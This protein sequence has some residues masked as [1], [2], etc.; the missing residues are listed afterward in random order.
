MGYN[1]ITNVESCYFEAPSIL[2]YSHWP[3]IVIALL[4]G[5][6]VYFKNRNDLLSKILF[7]ITITFSLWSIFDIITWIN[8][9]SRKVM[10]FWAIMNF[11][12]PLIYILMLY[13]AY[14]YVN[15]QDNYIKIKL[16]TLILL[17]PIL[18]LLP[19]TANLQ[20]FDVP[21]CESMQ[22]PM[23]KYIYF[24][25]IFFSLCIVAFLI[26]SYIK[27]EKEFKKQIIY[28]S[29]G[30]ISFLLAFSWVNIVGNLTTNWEITQ[31]GLFG[32][33][34]FMAML[35][36]LIVKFEAF[37]IKMI[38]AQALVAGLIILIG[39][40]FFFIK[41]FTNQILTGITLVLSVGFG[42]M[43][44]RSIKI[45]IERK[46]ELQEMSDKLAK[47]NDQLRKLDNAKSEFISIASHQL[48]T[49]L[50]AI[51]GFIS[52]LLEGSYGKVS[53]EVNEVL[54][55]VYISNERLIELVEDL[56]NLSRIESGR[57]EYKFEKINLGEVC[58]E[59]YDTFALR[60]KEKKLYLEFVLSKDAKFE[61]TTDRNK[62]REVISN[63]VDNAL[64]YTIKGGVKIKLADMGENIKVAITD[65]GI[66]V[67]AEELPYLF[68]KF[69]RGKDVSR[70][71]VGG[72]GLGL[73]VGK[74]MIEAL[75]GRIWV[76]S[77]GANM[78]STFFIE[79]PKE[80][81]TEE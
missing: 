32:M 79:A 58:Q 76:E 4:L 67:P 41:S 44:I 7:F 38:G 48:R 68:S 33:P 8:P 54:N 28:L 59:V 24:I 30:V 13:F 69:S 81:K 6:F 36:Y 51:K 72:T 52:L 15:K 78:G 31:Y 40:Q 77:A 70:L 26:R 29:A 49:P 45:E 20:Y 71:N 16:F 37:N 1:L 3:A 35:A 12:E 75:H 10:F 55:K 56:L 50:T 57:M 2:Y 46:N 74:R 25:E 53:K 63:L 18:I 19:T 34:I 11:L 39:S 47:A 64:K 66:G 62:I 61:A 43:L 73:H 23:I 21:S 27:A 65:T 22:G 5:L 42:W 9:D 60:A 80:M 14:I 17:L